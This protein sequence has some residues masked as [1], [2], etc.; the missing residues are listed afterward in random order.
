MSEHETEKLLDHEYDGIRE[1]DN[2]LP[3]WWLATFYATIIFSVIYVAH[4]H[5]GSGTGLREELAHEM[6]QLSESRRS[7]ARES[8][9]PDESSLLALLTE[10]NRLDYGRKSYQ[11]KCASCHMPKGEGSIGPN[12][13]DS[14]WIHGDGSIT[15]IAQL[16]YDGVP[17]KGMP[18]WKGMM[19]TDEI[20]A[21]TAFVYSLKG[22]NPPNAKPPQGREV[23]N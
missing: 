22:T 23:K 6:S 12:L 5:F 19:K 10:P 13:A 9:L 20:E 2:P 18:P 17:E 11:E 3:R 14:Y 16:I 4:Y 1:L 7:G 15:S 8:F 21:V